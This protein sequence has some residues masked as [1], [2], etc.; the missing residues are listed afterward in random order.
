MVAGEGD[1]SSMF[2]FDLIDWGSDESDSGIPGPALNTPVGQTQSQSDFTTEEIGDTSNII[3]W[4]GL[5]PGVQWIVLASL[6]TVHRFPE[7]LVKLSVSRPQAQVFLVHYIEQ[8]QKWQVHQQQITTTTWG[9]LARD[10]QVQGMTVGNLIASRRPDLSLSGLS[11]QQ[12]AVGARFLHQRELARFAGGLRPWVCR[13]KAEFLILPV[14]AAIFQDALD[15]YQLRT[16]L[17]SGR[18]KRAELGRFIERIRQARRER[19]GNQR[20]APETQ[21]YPRAEQASTV[22]QGVAFP[23]ELF[24]AGTAT[25]GP[26]MGGP[27]SMP[28]L[29]QPQR[30][31]QAPA[32]SRQEREQLC[33]AL[34]RQFPELLPRYVEGFVVSTLVENA[35]PTR[36]FVHPSNLVRQQGNGQMGSRTAVGSMTAVMNTNFS[37]TSQQSQGQALMA[38]LSASSRLAGRAA[39]GQGASTQASKTSAEAEFEKTNRPSTSLGFQQRETSLTKTR[40]TRPVPAAPPPKLASRSRPASSADDTIKTQ[41]GRTK[42][43]LKAPE[44]NSGPG[45][46]QA[47]DP[48]AKSASKQLRD[49]LDHNFGTFLGNGKQGN[50]KKKS[51]VAADDE[52][53]QPDDDEIDEDYVAMKEKVLVPESEEDED[54]K[55]SKSSERKKKTPKNQIQRRGTGSNSGNKRP[56]SLGLGSGSRKSASYGA[57]SSAYEVE[58]ATGGPPAEVRDGSPKV[59]EILFLLIQ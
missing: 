9:D 26:V 7:A 59:R 19:P 38:A 12:L 52:T 22:M 45:S 13:E 17:D 42:L 14:D 8:V 28:V 36:S 30:P 3:T 53:F 24:A 41:K 47:R 23:Q 44:P 40:I 11:V 46:E 10:A 33:L 29:N 31:P 50:K 1:V 15:Q 58:A 2:G 34:Q 56:A 57:R 32:T 18:I 5:A 39:P 35:Q 51:N 43:V 54:Y 48:A 27:S 37:M 4:T 6:C 21:L 16:A 20:A 25:T 55:P 49:H